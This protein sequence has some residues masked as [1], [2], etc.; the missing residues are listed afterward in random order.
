M[1]AREGNVLRVPGTSGVAEVKGDEILGSY[2]RFTQKGLTLKANSGILEAGTL[3]KV[4]STAK[5]Y[6]GVANA[7][8]IASVVG[9]LRKPV[10]TANQDK[11]ANYVAS[12]IVKVGKLKYADGTAV[13]AGD[14][15][16]VATA[17]KGR[18]D[19][20]HGYLIF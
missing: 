14:L 11:L 16:A 15:A 6:D 2:A 19:A 20:I 13:A 10:D 7:A 17:L 8:G 18:Y 4:S 12:G 5:K 9:I 3:L 1:A